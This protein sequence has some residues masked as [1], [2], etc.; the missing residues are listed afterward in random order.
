MSDRTWTRGLSGFVFAMF[1]AASASAQF[2]PPPCTGAV[3]NDVNCSGLFDAWIEQYA[4]DQITGG[5]GGGNYCPNGPVTR[6]QMAVFVEKAVRSTSTWSPGQRAFHGT[7][8]GDGAMAQSVNAYNDTAVGYASLASQSFDNGGTPWFSNNTAVGNGALNST[9]SSSETTGI[10]NTAVGSGAMQTNVSGA[11]NTAAGFS[12]LVFLDDGF[13]NTAV[14]HSAGAR[15]DTITGYAGSP[16]TFHV[17]DSGSFN[18]FVSS[19]GATADVDNCTAIGMDAYCD[20]TNQVRLGNFFVNSIGGKVGW[21]TLS[22][23]RAKT[24]VTEMESGLPLVLAL[25][26]V[27]YRLKGGNGRTDMGFVAQDVEAVLGDSYNAVDPGGDEA[28]TLSLR[29]TELIAPLV[30]AVQEQQTQIEALRAELAAL[31]AE[32]NEEKVD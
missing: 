14:G 22:D 9:H 31:R 2:A 6:G 21:S 27:T 20:A 30:K 13:K 1:A 24:D 23:V 29:Y 15:L 5:C 32:R 28:R 19:A 18:T 10:E 3:F 4:A 7:A 11:A 25:K 26:P 8:I 16:I 17:T 12:A